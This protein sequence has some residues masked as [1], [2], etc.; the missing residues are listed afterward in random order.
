MKSAVISSALLAAA[1]AAAPTART[2]QPQ[3]PSLMYLNGQPINQPDVPGPHGVCDG[4]IDVAT[5]AKTIAGNWTLSSTFSTDPSQLQV[6]A[7]CTPL[8]SGIANACTIMLPY[9]ANF[10]NC[11]LTDPILSQVSKDGAQYCNTGGD[12]QLQMMFETTT[13]DTTSE[14]YHVGTKISATGSVGFFSASVEVSG[15]YNKKWSDSTSTSESETRTYDLKPGDICNPTTV[16]FG[17]Q[18]DAHPRS[19]IDPVALGLPAQDATD[20]VYVNYQGPGQFDAVYHY[21]HDELNTKE[22]L[23]KYYMYDFVDGG[24]SVVSTFCAAMS[25]DGAVTMDV[26]S[27]SGPWRLQGCMFS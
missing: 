25:G 17:T 6:P 8:G 26:N 18:C 9:L 22:N 12:C 11:R 14:G 3:G 13:T 5:C 15:D 24:S 23:G 4:N 10:D 1:V 19:I 16:Q 21:C 2:T 20:L 27:E 7:D